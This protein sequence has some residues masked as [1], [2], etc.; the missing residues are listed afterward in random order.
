[1]KRNI[2]YIVIAIGSLLSWTSCGDE[3]VLYDMKHFPDEPGIIM[4]TAFSRGVNIVDC[5]EVEAGKDA[6][7]IESKLV[8]EQ[9]F[10]NLKT[11]GCDVVRI[12]MSLECFVGEAPD[13]VFQTT[14]WTKL[15]NLL[16]LGDQYGITV[17]IDNHSWNLTN[18][19]ASDHAQGF[20]EKT[21]TQIAEHCKNRSEKLVY[22]LKNEPDGDYW[23]ENWHTVQGKLIDLIRGI[24]QTHSIII[25]AATG[26]TISELPEYTEDNLIYTSHFYEP[27]FTSN[28][29]E[30]DIAA[31]ETALVKDINQVKERRG[32]M[33][34]GEFGCPAF[35]GLDN[36]E[37]CKWHEVVRKYLEKNHVAWTVF[38]YNKEFSLFTSDKDILNFDKDLNIPLIKALGFSVP[39]SYDGMRDVKVI[40]DDAWATGLVAY[41]YAGPEGIIEIANKQT[42]RGEHC[43]YWK[44]G[45]ENNCYVNVEI[46]DLLDVSAGASSYVFQFAIK[47]T[48]LASKIKVFFWDKQASG[49]AYRMECNLAQ[50]P[51]LDGYEII[52]I[53]LTDFQKGWGVLPSGEWVEPSVNQFDWK[54]INK[55]TFTV[56]QYNEWGDLKGGEFWIDEIAFREKIEE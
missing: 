48:P 12:P 34:V 35:T 14:F 52:Q 41:Y 38:S 11:L 6:E 53:P 42:Y 51:E 15:D 24:D 46:P 39:P 31:V 55:I 8:N 18:A 26:R 32:R 4:P 45:S 9:T 5:F 37:R 33:I 3:D 29:D 36:Q 56:E 47:H 54:L 44:V 21:W 22:E 27:F 30:G 16:D 25:C 23:K 19:F 7:S 40:F 43:I 50:L 13:Y 10:I 28:A 17:I 20:M 1:M 49:A 2:L